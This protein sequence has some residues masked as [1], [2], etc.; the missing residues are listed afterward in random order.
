MITSPAELTASTAPSSPSEAERVY[1]LLREW[2]STAELTPGSFLSEPEMA[3]RCGTSRTPVREALSRLAQDGWVFSIHRKGFQVRPITGRDIS[4][5]YTYRRLFERYACER[6]AQT[7]TS[8]QIA[9]WEHIIEL[10]NRPGA[11]RAELAAL[12]ER[13]H[14]SLAARA[15][16]E[17]VMGQMR[18]VM[19]YLRRLDLLVA[20]VDQVTHSDIVDAIKSRDGARASQLV[21]DHVDFA[22]SVMMR[23]FF[24]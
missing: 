10:E 2:I 17:R 19:A 13:F 3:E 9:E 14:L 7:A 11:V 16:N 24:Q 12:N 23:S 4:E 1:Q 15:E 18:L 8:Q 20:V 22:Q 21:A 6:A 5:L